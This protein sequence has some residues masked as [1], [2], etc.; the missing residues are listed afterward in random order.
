MALNPNHAFEE[1][2]GVKCSIVEKNCT[3]ERAEILKK[4]LELNKFTVQIVKSP[5]PKVAP[6]KPAAPLAEGQ[7]APPPAPAPPAPPE[8][9]IVGVTDLSFNPISAIY[10]K[11]LQTPEKQFVDV[12]YWKQ[13]AEKPSTQK[14]Y[15][16]K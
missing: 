14:W 10:N 8:T 16:E 6:P 11:E 7:V 1:L 4:L 15:W 3:P 12:K 5:P 2:D 13:E 9:F